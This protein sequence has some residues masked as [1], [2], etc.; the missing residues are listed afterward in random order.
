MNGEKILGNFISN[1]K[2]GSFKFLP[3]AK[4]EGVKKNLISLHEYDNSKVFD[5]IVI[6]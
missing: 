2:I 4:P 6:R 1:L 5:R 3:M